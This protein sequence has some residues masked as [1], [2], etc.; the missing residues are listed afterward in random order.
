M[1]GESAASALGMVGALSTASSAWPDELW[2]GSVGIFDAMLRSW[3]GVHEFTDDPACVFRVGLSRARAHV[4]LSD[5]TEI[6]AGEIIGTLHFW[7]EHLPRYP[8]TGPDLRWACTMRDQVAHSMCLLAD[9]IEKEPAW[10]D[11][12]AFYGDG[13]FF[14]GRLGMP[15]I[16]RVCM[17]F[18]FERVPTEPNP[19][20]RRRV[21]LFCESLTLWGL[22]RAFQPAALPRRP[23]LRPQQELWISRARLISYARRHAAIPAKP[24]RPRAS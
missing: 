11:I 20:R 14:S 12:R 7:N 19:S 4:I 17:R 22:T 1:G 6:A 9:Y 23:F 15:Q 8:A 16:E 18:G 24:A 2:A 10:H 21:A 5:G 13:V 3:Y